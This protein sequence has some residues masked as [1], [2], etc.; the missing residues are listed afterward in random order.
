M[1][2]K[3]KTDIDQYY[4]IVFSSQGKLAKKLNY[5]LNIVKVIGFIKGVVS[6]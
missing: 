2:I 6:P 3:V 1:L 4:S 5:I